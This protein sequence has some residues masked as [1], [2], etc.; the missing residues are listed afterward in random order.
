MTVLKILGGGAV[1]GLVAGIAAKFKAQTGC[2][3]QGEFG[4]VGMMADRLRSGT[5]ADLVI[6]TAALV[7]RLVDEKLLVPTTVADIGLV[8]TALAVRSGDPELHVADAAGLRSAFLAADEIYLP[9]T[10]SSTAGI[11]VATVLGRLGIA[12]DVAPRL[13]VY[14]NGATAMR[15]LA[16][17]DARRA[18]GCT[19]ST[20]IIAAEG[21]ALSGTFPP[22]CEL[23]TT[24]TAAVTARSANARQAQALIGLLTGTE[25]RELR[26]RAGFVG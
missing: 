2:E 8:E 5:P 22:G 15:Q 25:Q 10:K 18:V 13:R 17:S 21:V 11:H 9:D 1:Q 23:A 24:Y 26:I 14:P 20:E 6:L 16:A 7:A 3:I 4:A 12:D 19:Q